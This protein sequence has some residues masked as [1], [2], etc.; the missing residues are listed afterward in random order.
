MTRKTP[1]RYSTPGK[2]EKITLEIVLKCDVAGTEEAVAAALAEIKVPNVEIA[3]IQSGLGNISKSDV[4][5]AGTGSR[6]VIGFNVDTVPKLQQHI[7]E[8]G[9]EV[10]LY[11]TIYNLSEDLKKIANH[12]TVKEPREKITGKAKVI[13]TFKSR[14]KGIIIGCEVIEGIIEEDK[15]FRIITAMGPS[16]FA[17]I[18]SLQ[19]EKKNVKIGKPGQQ[20]GIKIPDWNKAKIGDLVECYETAPPKGAGLWKPDSGIFRFTSG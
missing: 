10:R 20:V 19:I 6:L 5:M 1:S 7:K 17:K 11:D 13:A 2:E 9:V 4:L 12:L 16:Y 8:H 18:E 3:V 15:N 14:P